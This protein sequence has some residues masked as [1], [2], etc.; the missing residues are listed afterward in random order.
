MSVA[1]KFVNYKNKLTSLRHSIKAL[2]AELEDA[3]GAIEDAA[4]LSELG[5]NAA[6][7]KEQELETKLART[8][9]INRDYLKNIQ[10]KYKECQAA[11]LELETT[12]EEL[13][14]VAQQLES[15]NEILAYEL[16][17]K[18]ARAAELV[19]ANAEKEARA[20]ELAVA[21]LELEIAKESAEAANKAKSEFLASM[22]HDL[23]TPLNAILGFS[24]MMKLKTFGPLGD[25]HYEEYAAEIGNS[26][27]LLISLINDVLDLSKIEAGKYDLAEEP[28]D[29]PTLI[30]TSFK[31]LG[32][33]AGTLNQT[34]S[35]DIPPDMPSLLGD[36]RVMTQI[37]NNLLSNAIKF[38]P[39]KGV[40]SVAARIDKTKNIVISVTDTGMGMSEKSIN[41]ALKF[42][43]QANSSYVQRHEGTG[44]GLYL[45]V[46]FMKLF[47]GTL[48]I[49]SKVDKG[50]T[51]ILRFPP[52]RTI[53]TS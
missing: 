31:Q 24:E 27:S 34:L 43:E 46:N 52:E 37:L 39:P 29:I 30:V 18:E 2:E 48:D 47:G 15:I 8:R 44:L 16:D 21:N 10:S 13:I 14:D 23:R 40:I 28:L 35:S 9:E 11:T 7:N 1:P 41:K 22:S 53:F 38:T 4:M 26:G 12:H 17:E 33:M 42:Y 19:I 50:T 51:V 3:L 45:C 5:P 6:N 32:H 20:V 49:Q 25:P 36:K